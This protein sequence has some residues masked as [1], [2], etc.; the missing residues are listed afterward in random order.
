MQI[1]L[2]VLG[3]VSYVQSLTFY[4]TE[5]KERCFHDEY[6]P[7]TVIIGNHQLIDKLPGKYAKEGVTLRV[8][9]PE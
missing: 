6:A 7:N 1:L 5:G 9:D 3:L 4:L 8:L 2:V